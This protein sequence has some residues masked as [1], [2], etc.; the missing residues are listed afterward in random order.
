MKKSIMGIAI[1]SL[2]MSYSAAAVSLSA[3]DFL[4]PVQAKTESERAAATEIRNPSGIKEDTGF[5]GKKAVSASNMQDAVIAAN[6]KLLMD[7]GIGSQQIK[8]PSGFGWVATGSSV[9]TIMENKS[10]TLMAQRLAY[11]KAFL[12]AKKSLAETLYGL[13][14]V[15]KDSL[16]SEFDQVITSKDTLTNMN[17]THTEYIDEKVNGL[18]R[19]YVVYDIQD[20]QVPK[21]KYGKVSVTIVTSPRTMMSASQI[22]QKFLTASNLNDGLNHVLSEISLGLVSPVGGTSVY[23]PS[24]GEVALV[25]FGSA[26][27]ADN[28]NPAVRA[29]IA[30]TAQKLAVMRARN[31]LCGI[32]I[33]DEISAKSQLDAS[34]REFSREFDNLSRNDPVSQLSDTDKLTNKFNEQKNSFVSRTFSKDEITSFRKGNVPPGV[35]VKSYVDE[36][37]SIAQAIAVYIPSSSRDAAKFGNKMQNETHFDT[38]GSGYPVSSGQ[39]SIQIKPGPSGRVTKDENL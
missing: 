27:I 31:S 14:T 10:A 6:N 11:Q 25:G 21:E 37:G 36:S 4:A 8:F 17:D 26:I 22:N 19:G 23:I 7:G 35:M 15:G 13:S 20:K 38:G 3:D 12:M 33:G 2:L 9:Y 39:S 16:N 28:A 1:L 34:T 29:K 30:L 24:T 18:I 32:I 5:D